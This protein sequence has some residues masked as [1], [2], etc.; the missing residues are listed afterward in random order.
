MHTYLHTDRQ[1]V[2]PKLQVLYC[3]RQ[4]VVPKL[5]VLYR[6]RQ[7]TVPKL[8]VLRERLENGTTEYTA[9]SLPPSLCTLTYTQTGEAAPQLRETLQAS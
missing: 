6:D 2:V 8:R 9:A 1:V 3:D 4:V 7:V 5:Q